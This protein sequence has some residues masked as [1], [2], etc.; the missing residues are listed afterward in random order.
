VT[1]GEYAASLQRLSAEAP[2]PEWEIVML[3]YAALHQSTAMLRRTGPGKRNHADHEAAMAQHAQLVI[4]LPEYRELRQ[5]SEDA[6]YRPEL[7][8]M[9]DAKLAHARK[10]AT[11]LLEGC[12]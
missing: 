1:N 8:P 11:A 2:S 12:A 5:L 3:F 7:H 4:W 9:P 6:R 10:L